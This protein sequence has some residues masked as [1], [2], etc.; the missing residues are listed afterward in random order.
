MF[1]DVL[2]DIEQVFGGATWNANSIPT[3]PTNYQGSIGSNV[4]EFI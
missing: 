4:Q 1:D 2:A 3:F